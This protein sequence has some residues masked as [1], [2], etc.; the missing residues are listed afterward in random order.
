MKTFLNK[1][2]RQIW[3]SCYPAT[4]KRQ[5]FGS[6]ESL[7]FRSFH[8]CF[9]RAYTINERRNTCNSFQASPLISPHA[10]LNQLRCLIDE[11]SL[12]NSKIE[13]VEILRKYPDLAQLLHFILHRHTRLHIRP[14]VLKKRI[15]NRMENATSATE[16]GKVDQHLTKKNDLFSLTNGESVTQS[17]DLLTLFLTL[18]RRT[19][20][21]HDALDLI[22]E[23]L[24]KNAILR[25]EDT[26]A[27]SAKQ[28]LS[29][30]DV[31]MRCLDRNLK[32]GVSENIIRSAFPAHDIFKSSRGMHSD[33]TRLE[34]FGEFNL[35]L[36]KSLDVS[37]LEETINKGL[38]TMNDEDA[39]FVSRKLDGVRCVL[40]IDLRILQ[41]SN[42][43]NH[44]GL[45]LEPIKISA[46][47]RTGRPFHTLNV[48]TDGLNRIIAQLPVIKDMVYNSLRQ[49]Q[50]IGPG[51]ETSSVARIYLD[52]EV[53][54]LT[55]VAVLASE[56]K[57][58][59]EVNDVTFVED[60]QAIVGP[61]KRKDYTIVNPAYFPFDILSYDEFHNWRND[62]CFHDP[63]CQRVEKLKRFVQECSE[64]DL[65]DIIRPLEQERITNFL[66]MQRWRRKA[67]ERGWEGLIIRKGG[68]YKGKRTAS[69]RKIKDW[70]EDEYTVE[71]I[72]TAMMRLPI[73][74]EY[75]E[76]LAMASAVI[77]HKG[78]LVHVGSGFSA[79]QRLKFAQKPELIIGKMMTVIYFE[80]SR[81]VNRS[82]QHQFSLRFPRM[83]FVW[84]EEGRTI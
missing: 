68:P 45:H 67:V 66:D 53:C 37:E 20:T 33:S 23:Y 3:H 27:S 83:K 31:F 63:F 29:L 76:R 25:E 4:G 84:N 12:T 5:R 18:K 39:W 80:E 55:P 9:S 40:Q 47:S 8:A 61:I 59:K 41:H 10:Q 24:D 75:A 72:E 79:E 77:R 15:A 56:S 46:L 30:L 7:Q 78:I 65:S 22:I 2:P 62:S 57:Q 21:G 36:G 28:P 34:S 50:P 52:G 81:S 49:S 32:V 6:I 69:I 38:E 70:Q 17:S 58:R 71:A 19:I 44:H 13:K 35:A 74:Q 14:D 42:G 11:L 26:L 51:C 64:Y 82:D 54:I 1:W 43:E 48:L 60:F 16:Q 73:G